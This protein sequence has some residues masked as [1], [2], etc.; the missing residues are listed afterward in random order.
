M[1]GHGRQSSATGCHSLHMTIGVRRISG[2]KKAGSSGGKGKG[3]GKAAAKGRQSKSGDDQS[4]DQDFEP[5]SSD[6]EVSG[7]VRVRSRQSS[8]RPCSSRIMSAVVQEEESSA[9][10]ESTEEE[11]DG[12]KAAPKN[13]PKSLL[14]EVSRGARLLGLVRVTVVAGH[15]GTQR[16]LASCSVSVAAVVVPH[17]PG[18]GPL[19][20]VP[21][22][23]HGQCR[24]RAH[25][26]QQVGTHGHAAAGRRPGQ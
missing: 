3:K 21:L 8:W 18:R 7:H 14:H 2:A 19:H 23:L 15:V 12:K 13:R 17:H 4:D 11:T 16:L 20:Q 9:D 26:A 10:D 6:T 24:L 22:H 1:R 5:S 25:V